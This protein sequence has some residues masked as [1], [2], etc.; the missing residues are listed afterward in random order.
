MQQQLKEMDIA[1]GDVPRL[2]DVFQFLFGHFLDFQRRVHVFL[3]RCRSGGI[4][5]I[6]SLSDIYRDKFILQT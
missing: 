6:Q 1:N 3:D 2:V 5:I 4:E